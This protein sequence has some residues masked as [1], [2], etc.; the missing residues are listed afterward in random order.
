MTN[1]SL[2]IKF[3]RKARKIKALRNQSI[4][5]LIQR[6]NAMN[7][8][9]SQKHYIVKSDSKSRTGDQ[10][11]RITVKNLSK[12]FLKQNFQYACLE[13]NTSAQ[14][15]KGSDERLKSFPKEERTISVNR[16]I[17]NNVFNYYRQDIINYL[18]NQ[19]RVIKTRNKQVKFG[20][21]PG[22]FIKFEMW[23]LCSN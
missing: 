23:R 20:K 21:S 12:L 8:T 10:H 13:N 9:L 11:P 4:Q 16:K 7:D 22:N 14:S 19:K 3:L 17:H 5:S 18:E 1:F 2:K 15:R 6:E